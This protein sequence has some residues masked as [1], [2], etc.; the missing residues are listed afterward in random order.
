MRSTALI[1]AGLFAS[2]L[3][4]G[5]G[6]AAPAEKVLQG[7]VCEE[8][9]HKLTSEIEWYKNLHKAEKAAADE[10]KLI[11][12]VHMVGKIDGAT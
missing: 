2:S 11:L 3:L 10:N 9:V 7:Q 6:Q 1:V 4:V 5:L 8:N 12:W